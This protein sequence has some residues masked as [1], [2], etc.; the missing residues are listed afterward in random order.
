MLAIAIYRS[1]LLAV[2]LTLLGL[3]AAFASLWLIASRATR[4]VTPLLVMD[5]FAL[6]YIGLIL[7]ASFVVAILSYGYLEKGDEQREELYVLLLIATLGSEVL[8]ASNHFASFLL[9]LEILSVSLYA[10][11]AYLR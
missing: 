9:G 3:A 1:H 6:F 10:L 7:A 5:R 11:N 8:V 2:W 4:Q